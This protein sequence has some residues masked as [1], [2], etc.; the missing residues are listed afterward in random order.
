LVKELKV[1]V[2]KAGGN[3]LSLAALRKADEIQRLSKSLKDRMKDWGLVSQ[4]KG[5]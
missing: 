4:N 1:E 5:Q 3:T 2:D